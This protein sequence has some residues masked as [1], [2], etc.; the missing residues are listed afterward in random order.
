MATALAPCAVAS[1][2]GGRLFARTEDGGECVVR[3]LPDGEREDG[4]EGASSSRVAGRVALRGSFL[5][6]GGGGCRAMWGRVAVRGQ[7]SCEADN[8]LE[9]TGGQG[10]AKG[11]GGVDVLAVAAGGR[12]SVLW[13]RRGGTSVG[14]R[15][16][17]ATGPPV[18]EEAWE[19]PW[20]PAGTSTRLAW[21]R[22]S[23]GRSGILVARSGRATALWRVEFDEDG[24]GALR[25]E[26]QGELTSDME[27]SVDHKD[28]D[29][30]LVAAV[31]VPGAVRRELLR[32]FQREDDGVVLLLVADTGLGRPEV[33]VRGILLFRRPGGEVALEE[34]LSHKLPHS[35]GVRSLEW[36][37]AADEAVSALVL[38]SQDSCGRAYVWSPLLGA[39]D[40]TDA[41]TALLFAPSV[42]LN[43]DSD[44][45]GNS[46]G[47]GDSGGGSGS[48]GGS[49]GGGG[50]CTSVRWL[51]KGDECTHDDWGQNLRN[52]TPAATQRAIT[53]DWLEARSHGRLRIY[54]VIGLPHAPFLPHAPGVVHAV[55]WL[56]VRIPGDW[57]TAGIA[58][59]SGSDN[60]RGG[61]VTHTRF[62]SAVVD[63]PR[64]RALTEQLR[65]IS[66]GWN[67]FHGCPLGVTTWAMHEPAKM[68]QLLCKRDSVGRLS[69]T[70]ALVI[71]PSEVSHDPVFAADLPNIWKPEAQV[72][73]LPDSEVTVTGSAPKRN[74]MSGAGQPPKVRT[75]LMHVPGEK[76]AFAS[77][78][79]SGFLTLLSASSVVA[80]K[81]SS[82]SAWVVRHDAPGT[83]HLIEHV[84]AVAWLR[85]DG[86]GAPFAAVSYWDGSVRILGFSQTKGAPQCVE[87]GSLEG[88][89]IPQSSLHAARMHGLMEKNQIAWAMGGI[90]VDGANLSAWE[91]AEDISS[92]PGRTFLSRLVLSTPLEAPLRCICALESFAAPAAGVA[93]TVPL[94]LFGGDALGRVFSC[95]LQGPRGG[96][97]LAGGIPP[98][99]DWTWDIT[100]VWASPS[101]EAP[102]D[103]LAAASD[104]RVAVAMG[105]LVHVLQPH[106]SGGLYFSIEQTLCVEDGFSL[107]CLRWERL[108]AAMD[109]LLAGTLS[110]LTLL[111][112]PVQGDPTRLVQALNVNPLIS[113]EGAPAA[114][115]DM[116]LLPAAEGSP[117]KYSH[118]LAVSKRNGIEMLGIERE[119]VE[120]MATKVA[121]FSEPS[122]GVRQAAAWMAMGKTRHVRAALRRLRLAV[123][124]CDRDTVDDTVLLRRENV[125]VA[126][127]LL[128]GT[129][130][131][132]DLDTGTA[133]AGEFSSSIK[134]DKEDANP[135]GV[136]IGAFNMLQNWGENTLDLRSFFS[137]TEDKDASIS[138]SPVALYD[139]DALSGD[140]PLDD[141]EIANIVAAITSYSRETLE[142]AACG[143]LHELT[144][145]I[146]GA[147]RMDSQ[148]R[149]GAHGSLDA[150]A[151]RFMALC[152]ALDMITT[153]N[154]L[155]SPPV[156]VAW[157]LLS[158]TQEAIIEACVFAKGVSPWK[159]A[160]AVGLGYWFRGSS[161]TLL[162]F[163]DRIAKAQYLEERDPGSCALLYVAGGKKS[164]L[165]RLYRVAGNKGLADFLAG[166]FHDKGPDGIRLRQAA[167]KNAYALL[168]KQQPRLA[169]AFFLLGGALSE[170][171]HVLESKAEDP[172]L[173]L[174][175]ARL[176]DA[177]FTSLHDPVNADSASSF[178]WGPDSVKLA[179]SF[180]ESTARR[181]DL[182]SVWVRFALLWQIGRGAEALGNVHGEGKSDAW[183]EPIYST[184]VFD[185]MRRVD[186]F[187]PNVL[188]DYVSALSERRPLD[189]LALGARLATVA[190]GNAAHAWSIAGLSDV[191][192]HILTHSHCFLAHLGVEHAD[193]RVKE[194]SAH[195]LRHAWRG[196]L[197]ERSLVRRAWDL[198]QRG[199]QEE[200]ITAS[201]ATDVDAGFSSMGISPR[202][203]SR[204]W[205]DV[206]VTVRLAS[207]RDISQELPTCSTHPGSGESSPTS[208]GPVTRRKSLELGSV[209]YIAQRP[210]AV[211]RTSGGES[212]LAMC[213]NQF[214]SRWGPFSDVS[215]TFAVSGGRYGLWEFVPDKAKL[216]MRQPYQESTPLTGEIGSPQ[217]ASAKGS[218]AACQK[219]AP[220]FESPMRQLW[221]RVVDR[222]APEPHTK[223][224]TPSILADTHRC[225]MSQREYGDSNFVSALASH[226]RESLYAFA[227]AGRDK[228]KVCV[229]VRPF[230]IR[231]E[232]FET[233]SFPRA[234]GACHLTEP[235]TCLSFS[236]DGHTLVAGDSSGSASLFCPD[237]GGSIV[238]IAM[239]H[240]FSGLVSGL[241]FVPGQGGCLVGV[242][243]CSVPR[244]SNDSNSLLF[245]SGYGPAGPYAGSLTFD[246]PVS[247][248]RSSIDRALAA[249]LVLWDSRS[250][251]AG[252]TQRATMRFA[253][254]RGRGV[255][256]LQFTKDGRLCVAGDSAGEVHFFDLRRSTGDPLL[257]FPAHK[258]P[259]T[260][261]GIRKSTVRNQSEL[262]VSSGADGAVRLW[263]SSP[264]AVMTEAGDPGVPVGHL[265]TW[266]DMHECALL[267]SIQRLGGA[268]QVTGLSSAYLPSASGHGLFS[269]GSDGT[270]QFYGMP[271]MVA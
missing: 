143:N 222:V 178:S 170:A 138:K 213:A 247:S 126:Q 74:S 263:C 161:R 122:L 133:K 94:V 18:L 219:P 52:L 190:Q 57:D 164:V 24:G 194:D 252:G 102:I 72:V 150:P 131:R 176:V 95:G 45:G 71:L 236:E 121:Q 36:F 173:A 239:L 37:P 58:C 137:T 142:R 123:L 115:D 151:A 183:A 93:R 269:C 253:V 210:K 66:S 64:V 214:D 156:C 199:W 80:G 86:E 255:A 262:L 104:G 120:K 228:E 246:S 149:E 171:L 38:L 60:G 264:G 128:A 54:A 92:G 249:G 132:S 257:S 41:P 187:Q 182:S 145:V 12:V 61:I 147:G 90:S 160:R 202:V 221:Q 124:P 47:G 103:A 203:R 113:V 99:G 227:V 197:L 244:N 26:P 230:T 96:V 19:G 67:A 108:G 139:E 20:A 3:C 195:V 55:A 162:G 270:V 174:L 165:M 43:G 258:G 4:G 226:P 14:M 33:H 89:G 185:L 233:S 83:R 69:F 186:Q 16:G 73:S 15:A 215:P 13:V 224:S 136:H 172:Q 125:P 148:N 7:R 49:E 50:A 116:L 268:G 168:G 118:C 59:D 10:G 229:G 70:H 119:F 218:G 206:E 100:Q 6:A 40:G 110:S 56:D 77:T 97:V 240:A 189:T 220:L 82:S 75:R 31:A 251:P 5:L 46:G 111:F 167:M 62:V 223:P 129:D 198:R 53:C 146:E 144:C 256:S 180:I 234:L 78:C 117:M 87:V 84:S 196:V 205:S 44:G 27:G 127:I 157:A 175:V 211:Y 217:G 32:L 154:T 225:V 98:L 140:I 238:P 135:T 153:E 200:N 134:T 109:V 192:V 179:K 114:I 42:V 254:P 191:A 17:A 241:A 188:A 39:G 152:P 2:R 48:G 63:S 242:A 259:V 107:S 163:V 212:L 169:A 232:F 79:L 181:G 81:V 260:G 245:E 91:I 76:C 68:R 193:G 22:N 1:W 88:T 34:L 261:L 265:K 28:G 235:P 29:S 25:V 237:V 184:H 101:R 35:D 112:A 158:D 209:A 207:S 216:A 8:T 201:L 105:N 266:K 30:P 208:E 106:S 155:V 65:E 267:Q 204:F 23:A 11:S 166:D 250:P 271:P 141:K 85:R 51:P 159:A 248:P 231:H 177:G 9:R 21:A 243:G 130:D